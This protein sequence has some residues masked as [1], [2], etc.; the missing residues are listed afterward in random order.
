M[1]EKI[2]SQ[3][4]DANESIFFAR[5]LEHIKAKS[6]DV[7]YPEFS[8][9]RMIPVE[10]DAGAGAQSITYQQ[11][12]RVGLMKIISNYAD[13]LPRSDVK[14]KEFTNPVRSIGGSYGYNIQEIRASQM[15]G[16]SIDQRRANACRQAYEQEI[17][18]IAYFGNPDNT[19]YSGLT[20]LIYNPNVTVQ[21]A[22]TGNWIGGSVTSDNIIKDVN[23]ALRTP[24]KLSKGVERP[25]MCIMSLEEFTHISTMRLTDSDLTVLDFLKKAHPGVT[26]E[27]I[28]ELED[29]DP[30]PSGSGSSNLM[31]T[32]NR[33]PDKIGLQ[34]PQG[35]EQFPAQERGLEFVIPAHGRVGGV[36]IY[37]P[38]SV[39]ITEGI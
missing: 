8:A 11:Y 12:D 38:L 24:I 14:G 36:I 26:F 22:T 15:A 10:S 20:G 19:K 21:S 13:D 2:H 3:N 33:N 16:K 29:V 7:K 30:K 1:S 5:E 37:Y 23:E 39:C 17:N 4:L 27:G 34:I 6:Y 32:Y 9:K 28:P 31:I 25:N 35:Y 18:D